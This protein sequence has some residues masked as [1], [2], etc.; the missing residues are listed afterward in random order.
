MV[1]DLHMT[2]KVHTHSWCT[3]QHAAVVTLKSY[4]R[5]IQMWAAIP[6]DS[7]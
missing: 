3:S 5:S 2:L 6:K 7:D 4:Y 1:T